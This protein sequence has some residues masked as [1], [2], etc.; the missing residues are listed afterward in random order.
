MSEDLKP[1]A[2]VA[3]DE[4]LIRMDASFSLSDAGFRLYEAANVEEALAH[5]ERDADS[6]RLLFTDVQMPPSRQ[7]GF[8]LAR[9]C[10]ERW[11]PVKI[12][13]ASGQVDPAPGDLPEGAL[14]INKP[15]SDQVIAA[16]LKELLPDG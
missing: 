4:A 11:P 13:V 9:Q 14:F 12:L 7:T 5:L 2:L 6:I 15:F 10:A 1:F 3:D 16:R 8:D